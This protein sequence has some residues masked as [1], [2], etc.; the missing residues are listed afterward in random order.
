[1]FWL[2]PYI[3]GFIFL[4]PFLYFRIRELRLLAVIIKGLVS[5]LFITTALLAWFKHDYGDNLFGIYV[6]IGLLF[7]LFGDILLDLKYMSKKYSFIFTVLGFFAFAFGH[8]FYVTGLFIYFYDFNANVMY[9]IVPV[10]ITLLLTIAT[11]LMEVFT[12]IKYGNMRLFVLIYGLFLF[13]TTSIYISFAILTNWQ[14]ST[15]NIMA[16]SF[17]FFTISDLILNNTY[18]APGFKKP[19]YI[20]TN[21]ALYYIA[22][23]SIAFSLFYLI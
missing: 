19:I 12:P 5:L 6:F 7:G 14:I 8:A 23:F 9:I 17:L 18:F 20:I 3:I 13:F 11:L 10:I 21:H 22:Q 16:V 15:I 1:M 4:I 2:I